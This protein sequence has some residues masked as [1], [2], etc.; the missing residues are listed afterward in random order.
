MTPRRILL[1]LSALL[2]V[3][4]LA[5][6]FSKR[7]GDLCGTVFKPD[8]HAAERPDTLSGSFRG[9]QTDCAEAISDA[10]PLTYV[11]LGVGVIAGL[12]ALVAPGIAHSKTPG[13]TGMEGK[14]ATG[15]PPR[16]LPSRHAKQLRRG[17]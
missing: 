8:N 9:A 11:A 14:E 5:M 13:S 3:V 7:S 12:I 10:K 1:V 15:S 4:A 17:S 2:I 6:G 16:E